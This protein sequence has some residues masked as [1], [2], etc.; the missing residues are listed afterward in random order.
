MHK[1]IVKKT[2]EK[3]RADSNEVNGI[4]C[5][6]KWEEN[7]KKGGLSSILSTNRFLCV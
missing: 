2:F 6:E 3:K 1:I 5:L 4:E 7:Q